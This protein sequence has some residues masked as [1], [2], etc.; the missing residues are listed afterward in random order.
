M[1]GQLDEHFLSSIILYVI[2]LYH[3]VSSLRWKQKY[4]DGNVHELRPASEIITGIKI[5]QVSNFAVFRPAGATRITE[6]K[7]WHPAPPLCQF[8]A[9]RSIFGDFRPQKHENLPKNFQSCKLFRA[10]I[11]ALPVYAMY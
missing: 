8:H 1:D 11:C 9:A 4:D 5:T 6:C 3:I 2:A 7:T 10:A